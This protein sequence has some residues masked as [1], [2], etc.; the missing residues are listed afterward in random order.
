VVTLNDLLADQERWEIE[1]SELRQ[2]L[3]QREDT[4]FLLVDCREEEEHASESIGG[5][6]LM[7]LSNFAAEVSLHLEDEER[8][9][10]VYCHLGMRSLNAT[11]YLRAKGH[12]QTYSLRGGIEAWQRAAISL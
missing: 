8:P 7:P 9:I 12:P 6:L 5:D 3:E 1:P 11:Q 2:L 10:V 4:P